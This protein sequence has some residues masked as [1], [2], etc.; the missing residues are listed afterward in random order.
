MRAKL[1]LAGAMLFMA[2]CILG[3]GAVFVY[4]SGAKVGGIGLGV[5]AFCGVFVGFFLAASED[6][7]GA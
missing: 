7:S 2:G 1:I 5:A 6:P 3:A 4:A